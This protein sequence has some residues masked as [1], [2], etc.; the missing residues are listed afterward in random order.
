MTFDLPSLFLWHSS[1]PLY[2]VI[3]VVPCTVR[4]GGIGRKMVDGKEE[5]EEEEEVDEESYKDSVP[6]ILRLF[7]GRRDVDGT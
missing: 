7:H 2:G 3:G 1:K 5:E 6:I 4:G